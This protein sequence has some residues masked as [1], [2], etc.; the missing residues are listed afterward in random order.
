M[1]QI[2]I[3]IITTV[4]QNETYSIGF[5]VYKSKGMKV[6]MSPIYSASLGL[7]TGCYG[8]FMLL[9]IYC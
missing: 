5:G 1:L 6:R 8:Y 7:K 2:V 9:D 3:L 4:M